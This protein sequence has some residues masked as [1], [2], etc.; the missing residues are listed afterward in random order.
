MTI[1]AILLAAGASAD[2]RESPALL[3]F[4]GDAM[5]IEYQVAQLQAAG[6]DVTEVVLSA[7]ADRILPLV[8]GDDVEPILNPRPESLAAAFRVGASAVPRDTATAIIVSVEQ[9]RPSE[10]YR[11]LLEAHAASG[12]AITR[13][14]FEG[15]PGWPLVVD[16][17]VLAELRNLTSDAL[18]LRPVLERHAAGI[19]HVTFS[20]DVV[21]LEIRSFEDYEHARALFGFA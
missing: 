17:A 20:S 19:T 6:V 3:S 16:G 15:T 12:A 18:G 5:L 2:L 11:R 14:T 21:L 7:D 10:V 9:P 8:S 4:D 13:P 1:A